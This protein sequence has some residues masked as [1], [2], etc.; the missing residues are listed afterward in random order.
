VPQKIWVQNKIIES[1]ELKPISNFTVFVS[2][3]NFNIKKIWWCRSCSRVAK[4]QEL[5]HP[6]SGGARNAYCGGNS[7][8]K[9]SDWPIRGRILK[10]AL[11]CCHSGF[12]DL[13][14]FLSPF[15]NHPFI[16]NGVLLLSESRLSLRRL[17][18][19]TRKHDSS[20]SVRDGLQDLL[21]IYIHIFIS[22]SIL[23]ETKLFSFSVDR[24]QCWMK[25]EMLR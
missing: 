24:I 14:F 6:I 22:H 15:C 3:Y 25:C 2:V 7:G 19:A 4:L 20:T 1:W 10:M 9:H 5:P 23:L 12:K 18:L 13:H 11:T 21:F 17:L 16:S 8:V